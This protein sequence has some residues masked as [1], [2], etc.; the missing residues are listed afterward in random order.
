M[1][2][3][4]D[5]EIPYLSPFFLSLLLFCSPKPPCSPRKAIISA[6][7]RHDIFAL[8]KT[9]PFELLLSNS[10]AWLGGWGIQSLKCP[11]EFPLKICFK[12]D[13]VGG[14]DVGFTCSCLVFPL[15]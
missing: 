10:Q 9:G 13:I 8:L 6:S 3:A 1:E 11:V 12:N 4:F 14:G 2:K 15:G 7:P 5:H